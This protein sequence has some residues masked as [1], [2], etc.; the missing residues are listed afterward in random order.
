MHDASRP[1]TAG[2]KLR[3]NTDICTCVHH[4]SSAGQ[5]T[6]QKL[7]LRT[8][9]I[10]FKSTITNTYKSKGV[11]ISPIANSAKKRGERHQERVERCG[12]HRLAGR[13]GES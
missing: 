2:K 11:V 3:I 5:D 6:S 4:H 10:S 8:I 1:D 7:P 12:E 9:S 13:G